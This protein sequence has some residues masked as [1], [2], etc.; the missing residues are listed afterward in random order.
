VPTGPTPLDP[1]SGRPGQRQ[2]TDTAAGR[3]GRG[4]GP[5]LLGSCLVGLVTAAL[6]SPPPAGAQILPD[7]PVVWFGGRVLIG[8]SVSAAAA[9]TENDT[10]F[11]TGSYREDT[12]RLIAVSF[13]SSV[14]L[15]SRVGLEADL[16]VAGEPDGSHW[17]FRPRTLVVKLQPFSATGFAV[18]A[19][20][21]QAAFGTAS[22]RTYGRDNL[23]IGRPLIYQFAAPIRGDAIPR[24]APELLANRGLG[25]EAYYSIGDVFTYDDDSN[26]NYVGLPLADP[27]GWNAGVRVAAGGDRLN[28][29]ATLTDG[30]ISNPKSRGTSGGWQASGRVE[31]RAS[32]GLVAGASAAYGRYLNR[33]LDAS[34]APRSVEYRDPRETALGFDVEYSQGYWLVRGEAIHSRRSVPGFRE[35]LVNDVLAATGLDVEGRYRLAPGLY[36][37]ARLGA[38]FFGRAAEPPGSESWD[39]D[40]FRVEAGPGWS[41]TRGLMLK[42]VYQYNRR[43]MTGALRSAHRVAVEATAWF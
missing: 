7:R 8:G 29:A 40:V 21:M 17:Y 15:H 14:A 20:L 6:L 27:S 42:S 18:A 24:N 5:A 12:M 23:L 13:T 31:A 3:S 11:N 34:I 37:A 28:V 39:A 36:V 1:R 26:Y 19:G 43:E 4:R 41:I 30:S 9:T 16:R 2:G 35:P 33:D 32:T 25:A 22:A 38:L 10:W